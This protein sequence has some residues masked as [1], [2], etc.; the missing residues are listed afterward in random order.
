MLGVVSDQQ[1][2]GLPKRDMSRFKMQDDVALRSNAT[3]GEGGQA[4]G[5]HFPDFVG[6]G[7]VWKAEQKM[8]PSAGIRQL[9]PRLLKALRQ[10]FVGLFRIDVQLQKETG[11]VDGLEGVEQQRP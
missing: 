4:A 11:G 10:G 7:I 2:D 5:N 6:G 3:G 1:V 8:L 9:R